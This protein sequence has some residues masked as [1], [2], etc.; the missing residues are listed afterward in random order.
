MLK[1]N[2]I[3]AAALLC[4][5]VVVSTS[6]L[7]QEEKTTLERVTVTGSN[8]KRI[9]AEGPLPVE[10]ITRAEIERKG[11]TSTNE[12]LRSLSYMSSFNDELTSNSP[13]A[14]GSATAGFRGLSGDQTVVL[15]NGR[16]LANYGFDGAFVNLNTIPLGAIQRVEVLKD[17]AAAIY[18]ADAIG[19]V[20]NFITRRDYKGVDLS[21][22]YGISSE[23]DSKET[24]ATG[25]V[26]FGSLERE[27]FNVLANLNYFKRDP[28]MNLDRERTKTGD[29]RRFGGSNQLSTFAPTGNFV[30]PTTGLQAPFRPC[31][32]PSLLVTPSPLSGS[33]SSCVFDFAPY[34][35][36]MYSTERLGG[37]VSGRVNLGSSAQLFGELMFSRSESFASAAGAP[38]NF[39]LPVGHPANPYSSAITV[40]GRPLQAGPRTTDNTS[41]ASRILV[42]VEGTV[43]GFD[44]NIAVGQ[45]KNKTENVDGGYFLLD[46]MFAAIANRTFDPFSTSNPQSVIDAIKS[47][48]VRTGETTNTF[49]DAKLST[50]VGQLGGGAIGVAAGVTLGREEISDVPGPNSRIG[51]IFGSIQQSDVVAKRSLSAVYAEVSLPF[52]KSLEAQLAVRHDRYEGGTNSTT[53]K[54]ALRYQPIKQVLLRASY[55]EG[56]KMPSLRDL[57]GGLNQSADSVQDF[58]GC[59]ARNQSPC[60]R[61]QYDRFSGGNTALQPEK[62]KGMNFGVQLEPTANTR[63]GLD[64][65]IIKKTDEIGLV[66]TQFV[67]DS[68][69][70]A[71]GATTNLGG[72]PA[73]SVTRNAG[74]TITS[75]NTSLGNLGKRNIRGFD[76]SAEQAIPTS[77]GRFSLEANGTYYAK[78]SYADQ[79]G[80][81]MYNRLGL[82]NLPRWRTQV[83]VGLKSG[84][85]DGNVYFNSRADMYDK[86]QSTAATP[87]TP[88]TAVVG[89]FDTFDLSLVY[90]GFK[91]LRLT[92]SV[93]NL[94]NKEPP[95]SNND[96]RTLGFS[97]MDDIRG[98]FFTVSANYTF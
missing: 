32:D 67:I 43:G 78:Y 22:S 30:N 96:T 49:V 40:R 98:R 52:T 90:T 68:V 77:I 82:L 50:E 62:A 93:K 53:P 59:A 25:T 76:L 48:D 3:S 54:V 94:F 9:S 39:T 84:N 83:R 15:L 8:I 4:L 71:P 57:F 13:N 33:G 87:V 97:Q 56:F 81:P 69:P 86:Q 35:T 29:Y 66:L 79:P 1:R 89:N 73:F 21:A 58:P 36:T 24:S 28:L 2:A 63:L 12:L 64:Y 95:F 6:A 11:V 42:G 74:G 88:T 51:N 14:T 23:G 70:Y 61:L 38:G 72:N 85:W 10:V 44:Y 46:K 26:G 7:A 20:I 47:N 45:A 19:G 18:G 92:G 55:S 34:R 5:G 60:P 27:G 41:E 17:G 91:N 16:R 37:L 80:T 31:P 65:F 75:V